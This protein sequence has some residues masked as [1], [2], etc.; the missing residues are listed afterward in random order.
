VIET[1]EYEKIPRTKYLNNLEVK[2]LT[3]TNAKNAA[4][5]W[6]YNL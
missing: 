6:P 4:R 1:L 2:N 5:L 3:E